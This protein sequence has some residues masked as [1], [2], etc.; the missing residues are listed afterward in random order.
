MA[1]KSN[2]TTAKNARD[3][4]R[5]IKNKLLAGAAQV[6]ISDRQGDLLKAYVECM[7]GTVS[8]SA[9]SDQIT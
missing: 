4:W 6:N 2:H 7:S 3:A 1:A 8:R 5:L 9:H